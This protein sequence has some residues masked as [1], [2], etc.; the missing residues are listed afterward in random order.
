MMR[1]TLRSYE[2]LERFFLFL[3]TTFLLWI[4]KSLG[5][6]GI[7]PIAGVHQDLGISFCFLAQVATWVS[8]PYF[9]FLR[10]LADLVH[11]FGSFSLETGQS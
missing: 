8:C 7:L 4:V 2:I 10:F 3:D 11:S 9:F 6:I 5:G 1:E